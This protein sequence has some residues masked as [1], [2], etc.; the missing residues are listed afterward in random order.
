MLKNGSV[1]SRQDILKLIKEKKLICG[2]IDL[3]TQLTPNGFDLTVENIFSFDSSGSLDFSN[4]ER[5]LP[6]VKELKARRKKPADKFGWW[7]LKKG[8]YKVRTNESVKIPLDLV[9][10]AFSRSTLL[11]MGAFVQNAVWDSGFEGKSEFILVIENPRG[12][13]VKENARL[14]Q[15]VFLK[16]NK[17]DKGYEGIYKNL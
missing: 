5:V 16:S 2:Y 6:K 3:K 11:R 1:L 14:N 12:I 8:A 4:K 7:H 10:V 15:L 9:A 17:A 13:K